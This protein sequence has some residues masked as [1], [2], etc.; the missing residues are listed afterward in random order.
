MNLASKMRK[1][2]SDLEIAGQTDRTLVVNDYRKQMETLQ[3]E[4]A[5]MEE[6]Y[7]SSQAMFGRFNGLQG[8]DSVIEL[9]LDVS[10]DSKVPNA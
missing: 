9:E 4:A 8:Q 2:A 6:T 7:K 5:R 10:N 1:H 3:R